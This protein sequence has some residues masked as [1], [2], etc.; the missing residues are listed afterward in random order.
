MTKVWTHKST[1]WVRAEDLPGEHRAR[2]PSAP[3]FSAEALRNGKGAAPT[4]MNG[5][6]SAPI[7][8]NRRRTEHG[9]RSVRLLLRS[10]VGA[11]FIGAEA[12]PFTSLPRE[13]TARTDS[14]RHP[15]SADH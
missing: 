1:A 9:T 15:L 8:Q 6:P 7:V 13:R 3:H 14:V 12:F 5:K 2:K 10:T 4:Q 11:A